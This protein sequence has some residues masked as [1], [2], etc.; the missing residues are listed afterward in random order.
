MVNTCTARSAKNAMDHTKKAGNV[1]ILRDF[2]IQTSRK[3]DTNK[4]DIPIKD[5]RNNSCLLIVLMVSME[6]NLPAG[7]FGKLQI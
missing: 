7:K 2:A 3:I 4:S 5:H 1:T 6:K